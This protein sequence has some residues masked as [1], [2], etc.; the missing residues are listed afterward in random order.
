MLKSFTEA[1]AS[2]ELEEE[3][4]AELK[5]KDPDVSTA[6]AILSGGTSGNSDEDSEEVGE[7]LHV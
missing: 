3:I 4:E 2:K 1:K 7:E 6:K 5:K